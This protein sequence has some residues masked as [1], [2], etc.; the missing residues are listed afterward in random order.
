MP[1]VLTLPLDEEHHHDDGRLEF[2]VPP[3]ANTPNFKPYSANAKQRF[4]FDLSMDLERQLEL[5]SLPNTP[6]HPGFLPV[7]PSHLATPHVP[8]PL[9]AQPHKRES[10]DS[11]ILAHIVTQLRDSLAEMTKERDDL[12]TLLSTAHT[13]EAELKDAL[14]HMTDKA[15]DIQDELI[16]A[17]RKAKDDEEAINLLRTKVEE[18]RYVCFQMI[19]I[20]L[21]QDSCVGED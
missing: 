5:E 10:L 7:T 14:Q 19:V 2:E 18:S 15:T 4:S 3:T 11:D 12:L 1:P 6:D 9:T 13:K 16:E 17:R 8:S 20:K 21:M